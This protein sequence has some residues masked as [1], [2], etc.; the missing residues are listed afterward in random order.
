MCADAG[1]AWAACP[2]GAEW[3]DSGSGQ[4]YAV[5]AQA[6]AYTDAVQ[7]QQVCHDAATGAELA[8]IHD[9]D[10]E[11]LVLQMLRN[12]TVCHTYIDAY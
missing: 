6:A 4:C 1:A 7:A 11:S 2:G 12:I 9:F 3:A 10:A 8:S 5:F